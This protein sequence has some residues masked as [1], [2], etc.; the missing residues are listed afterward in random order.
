MI[1][2][3]GLLY[4]LCRTVLTAVLLA[5][6]GCTVAN[7]YD[8]DGDEFATL[9]NWSHRDEDSRA[10]TSFMFSHA[11]GHY[12][13]QGLMTPAAEHEA[14]VPPGERRVVVEVVHLP[15][16]YFP[17]G[18]GLSGTELYK[19]YVGFTIPA[20]KGAHYR[21]NGTVAGRSADVW[22]E[23]VDGAR[24]SEVV[25]VPLATH[26]EALERVY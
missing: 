7:P 25:R 26:P 24:V 17:Q 6:S 12:L 10:V 5:A 13:F 8:I 21:A 2:D 20:R 18:F 3:G 22:V 23:E 16:G 19:A 15:H 9:H 11:D 14:I 4:R 1:A